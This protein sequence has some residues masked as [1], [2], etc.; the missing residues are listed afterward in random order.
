[1][2]TLSATATVDTLIINKVTSLLAFQQMQ[3]SGAVQANQL[4]LIEDTPPALTIGPYTYNG[5]TA[6]NIAIYDGT[7]TQ[8]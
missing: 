3:A 4:Y 7:Y 8:S 6:V 1:M 5:T 2:A